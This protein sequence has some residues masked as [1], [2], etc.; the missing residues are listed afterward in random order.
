MHLCTIQIDVCIEFELTMT[1]I[2]VVIGINVIKR[3]T[4]GLLTMNAHLI[5]KIINVH[6]QKSQVHMCV[7]FEVYSTNSSKGI[8][9]IAA[10]REQ[11]LNTSEV[12]DTYDKR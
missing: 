2:S 3:E 12:I 5:V 11:Q 6:I 8:D 4:N 10:K 1:N 7:K 9:I